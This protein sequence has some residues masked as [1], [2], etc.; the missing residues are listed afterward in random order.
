VPLDLRD[1][2]I[3]QKVDKLLLGLGQVAMTV[4]VLVDLLD[5]HSLESQAANLLAH[6]LQDVLAHVTISFWQFVLLGLVDIPAAEAL[7]QD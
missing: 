1:A 5:R 7:T 6:L 2:V 3:G 4:Y